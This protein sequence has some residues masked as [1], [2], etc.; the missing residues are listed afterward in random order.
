MPTTSD[1]NRQPE[2]VELA[3]G[4]TIPT[5]IN[6]MRPMDGDV[7][8]Y[9]VHIRTQPD[10]REPKLVDFS[11]HFSYPPPIRAV[12][13]E[14][15]RRLAEHE[16]SR[17]AMDVATKRLMAGQRFA[18]SDDFASYFPDVAVPS[19]TAVLPSAELARIGDAAIAAIKPKAGRRPVSDDFKLRVLEIFRTHGIEAAKAQTGKQERTVRRYIA[20][21]K[22]IEKES[23]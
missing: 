23:R 19:G 4:I 12:T 18:V 20:Q 6:S 1:R 15:I 2:Y 14:Q 13:N 17:Q 9:T 16:I 5:E 11:M 10:E 7:G 22:K 21:A 3:P 8:S